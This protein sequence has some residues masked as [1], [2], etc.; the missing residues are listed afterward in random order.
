MIVV[1]VDRPN[2][3]AVHNR[4]ALRNCFEVH[5]FL[6]RPDEPFNEG[7]TAV[8]A[9]G[10]ETRSDVVAFAPAPVSLR[11]KELPAFVADQVRRLRFCVGN[12]PSQDSPQVDGRG[13]R[14]EE[15]KPEGPTG[16]MIQNN[17]QPPAEGLQPN[18]ALFE[19]R[20]RRGGGRSGGRRATHNRFGRFRSLRLTIRCHDWAK[21]A[22]ATRRLARPCSQLRI[23]MAPDALA[24]SGGSG[25]PD[26]KSAWLLFLLTVQRQFWRLNRV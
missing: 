18:I 10:A 20:Y 5:G 7:D 23:L 8:L 19:K 11:G 6:H 4:P 9:D 14:T 15:R 21:E 22:N 3:R 24:R 13:R 1:P 17:R 26:G 25:G 16:V 2:Y 12:R